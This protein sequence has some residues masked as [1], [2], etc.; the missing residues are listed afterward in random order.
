MET[1]ADSVQSNSSSGANVYASSPGGKRAS[2][3]GRKQS[4]LVANRNFNVDRSSIRSC[5]ACKRKRKGC[6]GQR[7]CSSCVSTQECVYTAPVHDHARGVFTTT[8]AR[9]LS[10]GSACEACRRRKTKCD[11]GA[12]C[13]Y[14]AANQV[15]CVNN[16]ERRKR[17]MQMTINLH[18]S[19]PLATNTSFSSTSPGIDNGKRRA[20]SISPAHHANARRKSSAKANIRTEITKTPPSSSIPAHAAPPSAPSSSSSPAPMPAQ[21]LQRSSLGRTSIAHPP[22]TTMAGVPG[23]PGIAGIAGV[24]AAANSSNK[25][26][27]TMERIEDRL[28]RIEQLMSAFNP[29]DDAD[30]NNPYRKLSTPHPYPLNHPTTLPRQH[31]HSV[32]GI[33]VAKEQAHLKQALMASRHDSPP[34]PRLNHHPLSPPPAT[35]PRTP[36]TQLTSSMLNLTLSPS[37]STSSST[38]HALISSNIDPAAQHTPQ[39]LL[40]A[41]HDDVVKREPSPDGDWAPA[42]PSLMEQLSRKTFTSTASSAMDYHVQYPIYPLT[43]PSSISPS[44]QENRFS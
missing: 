23:V 14:C 35:K 32:Q 8:N 43:P 36:S 21:H 22:T 33:T 7:P 15:E 30:P 19:S 38:S 25:D 37:S 5:D 6:N 20:S 44:Q 9:R 2:M 40:H 12:P 26:D 24:A 16:A 31:R 1:A 27:P 10:S 42:M 4:F 17:S 28:S 13:S 29:A 34:P 11:G 39:P 41:P 3:S 18:P